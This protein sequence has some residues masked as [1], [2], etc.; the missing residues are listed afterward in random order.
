[1][2]HPYGLELFVHNLEIDIPSDLV[3]LDALHADLTFEGGPRRSDPHHA[4][5]RFTGLSF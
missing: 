1:M 2:W 5:S 4:K 3:G